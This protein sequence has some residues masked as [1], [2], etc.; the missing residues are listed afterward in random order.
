M[1]TLENCKFDNTKKCWRDKCP[2]W[3]VL[4]DYEGC[5]FDLVTEGI[6]RVITDPEVRRQVGFW[7]ERVAKLG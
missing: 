4:E 1:L 3:T 2:A 5:I 7:I 6:K